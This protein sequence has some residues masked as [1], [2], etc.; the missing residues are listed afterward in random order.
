ME[1]WDVIIIGGGAAGL[2]CAITAG[3][4]HRQVLLLEHSERVGKKVAISGGGRCNFTN[5]HSN[6]ES[7]L[8]ANPHFCKSALARYTPKDFIALV[9][10]H[11]IAYHEKKL[12]QLFCDGSSQQII[13]MLLQ[14]CETAGVDVTCSTEVQQITRSD[15]GSFKLQTNQGALRCKSLVIATG[16]ISIRP[17]GATEF[18]YRVA[19][20]FG[21]EIETPRPGLVPLTLPPRIQESFRPLSGISVDVIV[22]CDGQEFREHMLVTHRG[23]SGPAILQIS[24]YWRPGQPLT[25]NLLPDKDMTELLASESQSEIELANLLARYL[26]K[27]FARAWCSLFANSKPLKQY[28]SA[29]LQQIA[30]QLQQLTVLPSGTEGFKKAEVTAGGISTA[31]LSSQTMESKR[32]PGLYFIGEVVDVTGHLGGHNFQWAWASGF[33]AGQVV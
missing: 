7:F 31:E 14:E 20:Q 11:G 33:A 27:R 17:L 30:K 3:K 12:G 4:R 13:D 15:D 18:G 16:G 24:S 5:T 28:R 6:P 8:S 23:L 1:S 25:I 21:L 32:V 29:E 9:E 19:E 2:F 26:P 22:S 10:R